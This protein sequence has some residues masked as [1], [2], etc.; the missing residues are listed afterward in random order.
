VGTAWLSGH[1]R[2]HPATSGYKKNKK[3]PEG[4]IKRLPK[5]IQEQVNRRPGLPSRVDMA[6]YSH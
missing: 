3:S 4:K 5:A 1:I 6:I 2:L